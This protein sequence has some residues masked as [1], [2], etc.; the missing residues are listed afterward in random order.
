[1]KKEKMKELMNLLNE[2]E[3]DFV[4]KHLENISDYTS[5]LRMINTV[6]GLIEDD[7]QN[8]V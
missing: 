5:M 4:H 8:Y 7:S 6:R 2:Y 3:I 1:M